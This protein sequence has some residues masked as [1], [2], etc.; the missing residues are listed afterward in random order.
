M[1]CGME[2]RTSLDCLNEQF[3][4]GFYTCFFI[5]PFSDMKDV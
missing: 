4:I 3:L 1:I 5:Q 2:K